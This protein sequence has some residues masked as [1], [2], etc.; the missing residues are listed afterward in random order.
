MLT[1]ALIGG[2]FAL[3]VLSATL[4]SLYPAWRASRLPIVD[5]LRHNR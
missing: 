5:A 4:A 1:P 3:A 2:A